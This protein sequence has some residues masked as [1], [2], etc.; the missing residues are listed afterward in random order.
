MLFLF[1]LIAFILEIFALIKGIK[2]KDNKYFKI[3]WGIFLGILITLPLLRNFNFLSNIND[4]GTI[5]IVMFLIFGYIFVYF[6]LGLISLII[7]F[8]SIKN[9]KLNDTSHKFTFISSLLL[10]ILV[11]AMVVLCNSFMI[12]SQ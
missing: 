9:K 1:Y 2:L 12:N 8:K 7:Y 4:L 5:I 3:F 11:F 6:I 10:I